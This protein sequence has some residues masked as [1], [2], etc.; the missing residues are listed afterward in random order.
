MHVSM[1]ESIARR[2]FQTLSIR[3]FQWWKTLTFA[4]SIIMCKRA[5]S[6]SFAF[7]AASCLLS[8]NNAPSKM[9]NA[10]V[11]THKRKVKASICIDYYLNRINFDFDIQWW[12]S[13]WHVEM[14]IWNE[15]RQQNFCIWGWASERTS[16]TVRMSNSQTEVVCTGNG[17]RGRCHFVLETAHVITNI[18]TFTFAILW[19]IWR[20]AFATLLHCMQFTET[21]RDRR[22]DAM[23]PSNFP[24]HHFASLNQH[25]N[26]CPLKHFNV[27]CRK[28]PKH[29][30]ILLLF[31]MW[32]LLL[33]EMDSKRTKKT[34]TGMNERQPHVHYDTFKWSNKFLLKTNW[35]DVLNGICLGSF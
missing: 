23:R 17:N 34:Q 33:C 35:T 27:S 4:T 18:S 7:F 29:I 1:C 13:E 5:I 9:L 26:I 16:R 15:N 24:S 11:N 12:P 3:S 20:P 25:T 31:A 19:L 28:H 10:K 14:Q 32:Y 6:K 2:Y 22:S 8:M 30:N 21:I